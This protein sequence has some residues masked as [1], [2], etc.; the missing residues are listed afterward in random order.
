MLLLSASSA[1]KVGNS[2]KISDEAVDTLEAFFDAVPGFLYVSIHRE[3]DV[4]KIS[5]DPVTEPPEDLFFPLGAHVLLDAAAAPYLDGALLEWN[6][7]RG[8]FYVELPDGTVDA[9]DTVS[10]TFH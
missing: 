1:P 10:F 5:F 3:D 7:E 9:E 2:M 8:A 4:Y 6:E